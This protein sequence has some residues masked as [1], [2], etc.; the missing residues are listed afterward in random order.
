MGKNEKIPFKDFLDGKLK[1]KKAVVYEE[2]PVLK[3]LR[4]NKSAYNVPAI[5][6][7]VKMN[8]NTIR[9]KLRILKKKGLVL[10][11]KPFWA[12]NHKR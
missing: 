6:K 1:K 12:Y 10:H 3:L 4:T 8:E 9:S 7:I 2:H 5:A 11:R